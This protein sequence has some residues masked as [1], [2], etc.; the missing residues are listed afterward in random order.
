LN[1]VGRKTIIVNLDPANEQCPYD[2]AINI[3]DLIS[4]EKVM[5]QTSLGPNGS[6]IFCM[7]YLS[8]SHVIEWLKVQLHKYVVEDN[9]YVLFD[10]PGQIELYTHYDSVRNLCEVMTNEWDFRLAAVNLVDA[11]YC[12]DAS[13]FISVLL[14]SLS[15]M[16]RLELPHI[17]VL[18]KIDLI[19]K[20]GKLAFD[21]DYYTDVE[22][23]TYLVDHLQGEQRLK[24]K[25]NY[26]HYKS[27][28]DKVELDE[29]KSDEDEV[30]ESIMDNKFAELNRALVGIIQDFS[31]VQFETLDISDKNSVHSVIKWVDKA[32]GYVFGACERDNTSINEIAMSNNEWNY[33]RHDQIRSKYMSQQQQQQQQ[34]NED[35]PVDYDF[36]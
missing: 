22:D 25:L 15:M 9:Y 7:E 24:R 20:Y 32:S 5:E 13:N 10:C 27:T 19:E 23:L 26:N 28:S 3:Q 16:M 2:C 4:L 8:Q 6:M 17:N 34:E 33:E 29:E 14:V 18:S 21:I 36:V 11:I 35:D 1:G 31:M 12:S 30:E